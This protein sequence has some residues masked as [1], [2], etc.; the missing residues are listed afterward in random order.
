MSKKQRPRTERRMQERVA[1]ALVRDREKL[2]ALERGGA[3]E[4]PFEVPSSSVIPV[5][6][7]AQRCPLCDGE[8]RLDEERA[9]RVAGRAL[10]ACD[11]TCV[12]CGVK[13]TL[14][15]EI[16]TTLPS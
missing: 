3:P 14:W 12:L 5:R 16:T 2:A 13:R 6:A 1:R 11:M 9:E 4:R 10:R 7:R 8:L 15:F